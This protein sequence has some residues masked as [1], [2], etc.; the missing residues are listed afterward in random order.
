MDFPDDALAIAYTRYNDALT[1]LLN[2]DV[3]GA[4]SV[5]L[6]ERCLLLTIFNR[7]YSTQRTIANVADPKEP[8]IDPTSVSCP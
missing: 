6:Q 2:A 8:P 7:Y 4:W 5:F 3:N 1:L